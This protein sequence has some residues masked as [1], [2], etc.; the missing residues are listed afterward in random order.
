[1]NPGAGASPAEG[2]GLEREPQDGGVSRGTVK[3]GG[4]STGAGSR[5]GRWRSAGWGAR[6]ERLQ[7]PE[8][9]GKRRSSKVQSRIRTPRTPKG[10]K[11]SAASSRTWSCPDRRERCPKGLGVFGQRRRP[12]GAS[13]VAIPAP[14]PLVKKFVAGRDRGAGRSQE[15][16]RIGGAGAAGPARGARRSRARRLTA[17]SDGLRESR[18]RDVRHANHFANMQPVRSMRCCIA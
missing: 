16:T 15:R 7:L 5:P 17:A 18:F 3:R 13:V 4:L 8:R 12:G 2:E 6:Q 10:L 9:P 14:L 11:L 1:M